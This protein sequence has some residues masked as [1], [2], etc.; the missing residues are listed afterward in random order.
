MVADLAHRGR[1]EPG[2]ELYGKALE[3]FILLELSAHAQ[4]T[5]LFYPIAYWRTASQFE[6]DFILGDA[7]AAIE[8]KAADS[9]SDKHL[10]GL[11]AFKEE[12]PGTRCIAVSRDPFLRRTRDGIEIMP[13]RLFLENL[14]KR[15][16]IR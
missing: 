6:V 9:V 8:V 5:E 11:R 2:S 16:I 15:E 13:W 10:T 12:H 4:Y 3:H 14:W 7:V 1:V